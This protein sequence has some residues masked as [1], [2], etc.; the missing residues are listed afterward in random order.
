MFL[1]VGHMRLLDAACQVMLTLAIGSVLLNHKIVD[2]LLLSDIEAFLQVQMQ[3]DVD[4]RP[5]A[6]HQPR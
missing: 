3:V 6:R 1:N 4:N 5:R 2:F